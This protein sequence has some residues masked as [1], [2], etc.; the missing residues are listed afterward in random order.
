MLLTMFQSVLSQIISVH[1]H[2]LYQM[3]LHLQMRVEDTY[4]AVLSVVLQSMVVH[5]ESRVHSWLSLQRQLLMN[6]RMVIQS[7][8]RRESTSSRL[9]QLRKTSSIKLSTRVLKSLQVWK[10]SLLLQVQRNF[11]ARIHSSFTI[12][13]DSL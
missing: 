5:L 8:G 13:T 3:V 11:Q 1:L 6:A 2:S 12:L 10:K 4:F 9:L 7:F